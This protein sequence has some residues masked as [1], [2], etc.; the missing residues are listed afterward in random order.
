MPPW[1]SWYFAQHLETHRRADRPT[2]LRLRE[3]GSAESSEL[4]DQ[5]ATAVLI[6]LAVLAPSTNQPLDTTCGVHV[7]AEQGVTLSRS[8]AVLNSGRELPAQLN[9]DRAGESPASQ[10]DQA[11]HDVGGFFRA[12]DP[13]L[14]G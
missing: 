5:T 3:L 10:D 7:L 4:H 12:Q 14:A 2:L 1:R 11:A 9:S 13:L 8:V 6:S